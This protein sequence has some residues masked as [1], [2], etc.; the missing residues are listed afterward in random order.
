MTEL[1][2]RILTGMSTTMPLTR[3]LITI[4]IMVVSTAIV[5]AVSLLY[6]GFATYAERKVA[7]DIQARIGPNRVG[8]YG[9][10]QFVADGVKLLLKEDIIPFYADRWLFII[11]PYIVFTVSFAA[12]VPLSYSD[13]V[14][15]ANLNVG[16][17]YMIAISSVVS[18]AILMGAWGSNNKWSLFGGMR[19]VAQIVSY[20]IP[21]V[22]SLLAAIIIPASLNLRDIIAYQSGGLGIFRWL[23]FNNPFTLIAFFVYFIAAIAE[24]NRTPFDIPEAE[25]EIVAGYHTEYT[26]MRFAFFFMAEYG[27]MFV[28]SAIAATLFL[29]GWQIP[30]IGGIPMPVWLREVLQIGVFFTKVFLLIYV[31]MWI[32]WTL[33]RLRVDQLMELCWKYL[34]PIALFNLIGASVWVLLLH[35]KGVYDIIAR[36]FTR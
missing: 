16:V 29:G 35:D 5:L 12:F 1:I 11:A 23:V 36:V 3:L 25:S 14:S 7:G 33:P 15:I 31:M 27:D 19:A 28:V 34:T 22:L 20:E 8:P 6:E 21:I 24:V 30:F 2:N 26:G 18:M 32:R 17:L 10:L 4:L 13:H 9:L